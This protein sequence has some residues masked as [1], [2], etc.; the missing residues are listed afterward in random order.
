MCKTYGYCRISTPKQNIERQVRNILASFPNA[1][2]RK[3]VYTGTK[4]QGRA[5]LQ[6]ILHKVQA[7]DTIVFDSVS[8]MSRN[9]K[10]GFD[11][12]KELYH[13]GVKLVFI[14]ERHIDTDA[15]ENAMQG[16]VKTTIDSGDTATDELVNSIMSAINKFMMNKVEQDIYAAFEQAQLENDIRKQN[17]K[18][19]IQTAKL[20]GKAVGGTANKGKIYSTKKGENAKAIIRKHS[21]SFGGTLNNEELKQMCNVSEP[22]LLKYKKEIRTEMIEAGLLEN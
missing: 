18:E 12:Y 15:Y 10:E 1:D 9:A 14:K 4:Y 13:R 17:T 5:E 16:I 11:I 2:I 19:G 7:G 3:E 20:S 21:K 6:K 8:R 22:T